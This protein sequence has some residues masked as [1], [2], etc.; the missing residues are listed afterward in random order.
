MAE[1]RFQ[2]LVEHS[3]LVAHSSDVAATLRAATPDDLDAAGYISLAEHARI[4]DELLNRHEASN[5]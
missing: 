3:I 2:K 5:G 1:L 4:V